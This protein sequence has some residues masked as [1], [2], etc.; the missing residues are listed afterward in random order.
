MNRKGKFKVSKKNKSGK[1]SDICIGLIKAENELS[2]LSKKI[3]SNKI[4]IDYISTNNPAGRNAHPTEN[5][6][7]V[8]F[9]YDGLEITIDDYRRYNTGFIRIYCIDSPNNHQRIRTIATMDSGVLEWEFVQ[10]ATVDKFITSSLK[11]EP[12]CDISNLSK[13]NEEE[14]FQESLITPKLD[15][16]IKQYKAVMYFFK[17]I[18][19][20]TCLMNIVRDL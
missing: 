17:C 2:A 16:I 8:S 5:I 20:K 6:I 3:V 1:F 4:E 10:L 11:I 15:D 9:T 14:Y 19:P 13:L 12:V 18:K 7:S